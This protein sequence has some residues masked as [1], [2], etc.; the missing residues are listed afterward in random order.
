M[1]AV[2]TTGDS[3]YKY[4]ISGSR[5]HINEVA[6]SLEKHE[7]FTAYKKTQFQSHGLHQIDDYEELLIGLE[8]I[9]ATSGIDASGNDSDKL[10]DDIVSISDDSS[11]SETEKKS[12]IM[13]RLGQ[14][15]FRSNVINDWGS[16]VCALTL[17]PIRGIL[18]ASHIK[19]WSECATSEERLDGSNGLLLCAHIDRLFDRYHI[20]FEKQGREY[21]LIFSKSI[22]D[23]EK[24]ILKSL[25]ISSSDS[26]ACDNL[27]HASRRRF[28]NYMEYHQQKFSELNG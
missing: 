28:E 10:S 24:R 27:S 20:T 7:W 14:G 22:N 23:E 16:E 21:Q 4:T 26:L 18:T 25:G 15:K 5:G 3:G 13:A 1:E 6:I 8:K 19:P 12:Y 2:Y 9:R 11:L 17:T